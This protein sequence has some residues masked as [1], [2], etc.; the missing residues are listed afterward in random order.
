MFKKIIFVIGI[1]LVLAGA[2][3]PVD[4]IISWANLCDISKNLEAAGKYT[5]ITYLK[6]QL[7]QGLLF[8]RIALL[9]LGIWL[10]WLSVCWKR[11]AMFTDKCPENEENNLPVRQEWWM[12]LAWFLFVVLISIPLLSKGFEHAEFVNYTMLAQRGPLVTMACQNLPPRAAQVAFT[13]VESL[14]VK[15]FGGGETIARLPAV[16]FGGLVMFPLFFLA[17]RFGTVIFSNLVCAGVSLT[18]FFLF[19][20]SYAK[21]YALVMTS[22]VSCVLL[23]VMLR[24]DSGWGMWSVFGG[25]LVLTCYAHMSSFIFL[26]VLGIFIVVDRMVNAWNLLHSITGTVKAAVKP[27]VISLTAGFILFLLYSPGIPAELRYMQ[28]FDLTNY[29]MAYHINPRFLN[30]MIESWAWVRDCWPWAL[31]QA[32]MF[33]I[34]VVFAFGKCRWITLYIIFPAVIS[35]ALFWSK[36]LF[37][38]PRF[39]INFLPFY[40]LFCVLG[41]R[42]LGLRLK[43]DEKKIF[44]IFA[45]CLCVSAS[46]T[47]LR[48]YG[49]ERCGAKTVVDDVRAMASKDDRVMA[50]LDGYITVRY[51]YPG[52]VSGYKDVDFWYEVKS[53]KPP[54]YV[55][56]VPYIDCDIPGGRQVLEEKY[57]LVKKYPS[58]LDV[59]DDQDSVYLYQ[60]KSVTKNQKDQT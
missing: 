7:V 3:L 16:F 40:V 1:V 49:M 8:T 15:V 38:Y 53:E 41:I 11:L 20:I 44:A 36:N 2:F 29:Y 45:L 18:G 34:G 58:W 37:V 43:L 32:A 30:V 60:R 50:V 13:V 27:V 54:E 19:Y 4:S 5:R 9:A 52:V 17:R 48:L 35:V 31:L 26:T 24:R 6:N 59:D 14:F 22:Y 46:F 23:A 10:T 12:P 25:F 55:I 21:G 39:F 56:S 28:K 57:K 33:A 47:L 51:Y 42:E